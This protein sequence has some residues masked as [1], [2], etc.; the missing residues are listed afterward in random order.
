[1]AIVWTVEHVHRAANECEVAV[2]KAQ[3]T[4]ILHNLYQQHNRQY[5]L[6]WSDLTQI[7]QDNVVGRELTKRELNQFIEKDILTIQR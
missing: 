2:T 1:M 3:A 5:G 6:R 7:I 4:Q